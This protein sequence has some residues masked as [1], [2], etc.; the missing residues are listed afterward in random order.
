MPG[1]GLEWKFVDDVSVDAYKDN[2][3]KPK[4]RVA[5]PAS[6]SVLDF[7]LLLFPSESIGEIFQETTTRFK[8]CQKRITKGELYKA[9]SF[10]MQ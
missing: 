1:Y 2:R 10:S 8:S 4:L 5:D 6:M 9:I 7:W 3:Y